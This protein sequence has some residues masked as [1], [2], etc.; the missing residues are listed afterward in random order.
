MTGQRQKSRSGGERTLAAEQIADLAHELRSP[1][2][3]IDAMI[4]LL[5]S[6]KTSPE[7]DQLLHGLRAASAHMR[8]VASGVIA[9]RQAASQATVGEIL[10]Q[11]Q[12]ACGARARARELLYVQEIGVGCEHAQVGDATALRQMLENLVDNAFRLTERGIVTV[13]AGLVETA[14]KQVLRLDVLDEGPGLTDAEAAAVFAR[15]ATLGDRAAGTGLGL[16]IVSRLARELGGSCGAGARDDRPGAVFWFCLPVTAFR[17]AP[18][19]VEEVSR[20]KNPGQPLLI[21]DDDATSRLLLTTVLDH[22]G[23]ETL[24]VDSP[25]EALERLKTG[26]FAAVFTDVS[27]PGMNGMEFIAAVRA[28]P[29]AAS[30]LPLVSVSGRV[31]PEDKAMLKAA[32]CDFC[33]DKPI[34][35]HDLR[36]ALIGAKLLPIVGLAA[37]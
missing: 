24:A 25:M 3:G 4:E 10:S 30:R 8:A 16:S 28:L 1:L 34:T 22:L 15:G 35:I 14:G 27:M 21:V 20:F 19:P 29:G 36:Q 18:A 33:V 2:G 23:F 31:A 7:Q 5:A 37:A 13:R 9:P 12:I 11:F 26:R 6:G 17:E 32:G